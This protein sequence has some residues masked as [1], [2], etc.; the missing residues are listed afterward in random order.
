M[1]RVTPVRPR[2]IAGDSTRAPNAPAV[3]RWRSTVLAMDEELRDQEPPNR[4]NSDAASKFWTRLGLFVA[5][6][7]WLAVAVVVAFVI[8]FTHSDLFAF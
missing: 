3:S 4:H 6:L 8:L 2:F 5:V 1:S 7:L